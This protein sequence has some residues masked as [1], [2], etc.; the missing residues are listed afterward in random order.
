MYK[1]FIKHF[2]VILIIFSNHSFGK[3]FEELFTIYMPIENSSEI[4]PTINKS[5]NNLIFRISGSASPSNVWKI[6]NSG[7][8]RK[9]FIQS[10]SI[11]NINMGSYLEVN[12]DQE[13]VVNKFKELSIPIVGYSRPVIFFLIN[14]ESGSDKPYYVTEES[15]NEID[16]LIIKTLADLSNERGLFLELPVL[17]LEDTKY[18]SNTNILSSP[19][20]YLI[21]KYDFDEFVDVKLTNLGLNQW[22]F[23]GDI[24]KDI[25][26]ENYLEDIKKAL[27]TY[28]ESKIKSIYKNLIIDTSKTLNL[29]ITIEGI[30]SYEEYEISKDKL[31][32]IIAISNIK[33]LSFRNNTIT[34]KISVMGDLNSFKNT[35]KNNTFFEVI[36]DN[37][38]KSLNL[39]F[40][41]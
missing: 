13:L 2:L 4:E 5:F 1:N 32:K 34:Y 33:I 29:D 36:A 27:I 14:I 21:S 18:I 17:D 24:E 30:N 40:I 23:S 9:D 3:E 20:E 7:S 41:K 37:S 6:I 26:I 39:R 16:A 15:K 12:F 11:K 35:I 22:I 28:I 10:Y 31:S 8:S 25:S 38:K 19:K